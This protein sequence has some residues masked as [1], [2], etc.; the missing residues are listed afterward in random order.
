MVASIDFA[1]YV[2][3]KASEKNISLNYTQLQKIVYIC[4]GLLLSY[5]Y[6]II[7]ENCRV[8]DY[9]PVY[10]KIYKW[11]SKHGNKCV[12]SSFSA[13]F[14]SEI[15]SSNADAVIDSVLEKFGRMPAVKLSEW[16]HQAG[17][18]WYNAKIARGL[19]S[20]I[21]KSDIRNFFSRYTNEKP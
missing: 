17:S 13:D 1:K 19:Y 3:M 15:E 20:R 10:P 5:G 6:N 4:D 11:Y 9:G 2:L 14:H 7:N 12:N 21:E 8:W 16:S 18:P